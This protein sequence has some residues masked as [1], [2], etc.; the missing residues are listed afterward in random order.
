MAPVLS[1]QRSA[2]DA[3]AAFDFEATVEALARQ[4]EASAVERDRTGGHAARERELI[5]ASGLLRLSIP[6]EHGG[7]GADL[8]RLQHSVRRLAEVDSA[9]A[10]VYAFHHLQ[11]YS[12][13]LY[14]DASQQQRL[15][16]ATVDENLFW[17]NALNP[18]DRRALAT[19]VPGGWRLHGPK[20]FC[21]GARGSDRLLVSAWHAPSHGLL[22]ASV[23]TRQQGVVVLSDWDAFGQKQT[24]SGSVLL[25]EVFVPDDA[26][27]SLPGQVPT[28]RATLRTLVAQLIMTN[29]Y[30]GLAIGA[31]EAALRHLREASRPWFASGVDAATDDPYLQLRSAELWLKIRPATVLADDAALRLDA[32]LQRGPALEAAERGVVAIAVAEAKLLAHRASLEVGSQLFELTGAR[33]TSQRLGLDRYW[34]NARV[35]TLHDPADYKLRDLGRWLIDGRAP[36]PTPYS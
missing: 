6:R 9:L 1:L 5:R 7:L 34:R 12:V 33:A 13:L 3:D 10:H 28:P 14:G 35:H 2:P 29:L 25:D 16:R 27:L 8:A 24:D 11:L 18:L 21:S 19:P 32:A 26:V 30:L 15:W 36:D 31:F 22:I 20:S 23:P 4:L 17:G